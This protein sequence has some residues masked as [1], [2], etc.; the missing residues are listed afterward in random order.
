MTR[1]INK[2]QISPCT[3]ASASATCNMQHARQSSS[4]LTSDDIKMMRHVKV[5]VFSVFL[6]PSPCWNQNVRHNSEGFC[7][8]ADW[9]PLRLITTSHFH[10]KM[11]E[12]F[13][14]HL[15]INILQ[16]STLKREH[17]KRQGNQNFCE[18]VLLLR[19]LVVGEQ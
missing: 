6:S 12:Y 5:S 11:Y 17:N 2:L 18:C 10:I 14:C 13:H 8:A 4:R 7:A 16:Y 9:S 3:T 15:Y 1:V 19:V